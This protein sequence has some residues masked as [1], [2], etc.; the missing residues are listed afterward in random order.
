MISQ[1]FARIL[2]LLV[3][4]Y[5][6]GISPLM[7]GACRYTPTCSTYMVEAIRR[8]GP[9]KGGWMGMRRISRCHPWGGHGY[10]PV[11]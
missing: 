1:L 8:Y 11:P 10:D 6:Y 5:Q 9:L 4:V 7:P 2:I 3:N